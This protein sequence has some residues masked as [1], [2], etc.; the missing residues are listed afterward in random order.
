MT[1]AVQE[2]K[3]KEG[4]QEKEKEKEKEN[5]ASA[6]EEG[7]KTQRRKRELFVHERK[8]VKLFNRTFSKLKT[9]ADTSDIAYLPFYLFSYKESGRLGAA[10]KLVNKLLASTDLAAPKRKSLHE[11]RMKLFETLGWT[12]W[13]AYDQ[14]LLVS[15]FPPSFIPH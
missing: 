8:L 3:E 9:W 6:E 4:G 15:K 7:K 11:E 13:K 14:R 1:V 10:L 5:T 12:H 2:E